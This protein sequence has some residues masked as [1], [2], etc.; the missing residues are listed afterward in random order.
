MGRASSGHMAS[1]LDL[2]LILFIA[3]NAKRP[4][5]LMPNVRETLA[6]SLKRIPGLVYQLFDTS[7]VHTCGVL[8]LMSNKD[9]DPTCRFRR[10][11]KL[12]AVDK[13][14]LR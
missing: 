12:L 1:A 14:Q 13:G 4:T 3:F 9:H 8:S 11:D 7:V 10:R 5:L 6:P 2:G